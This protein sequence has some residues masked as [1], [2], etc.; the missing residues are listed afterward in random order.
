MKAIHT[1]LNDIYKVKEIV[2]FE[3]YARR[4]K[5]Q[6]D[7]NF[8]AAF[9]DPKAGRARVAYNAD[10]TYGLRNLDANA[11]ANPEHAADSSSK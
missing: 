9:S 7:P 8:Y 1:S 4:H 6:E 3:E 2:S 5:E 11:S 10:K